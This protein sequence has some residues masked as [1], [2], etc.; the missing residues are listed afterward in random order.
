[1]AVARGK[2]AAKKALWYEGE[3]ASAVVRRRAGLGRGLQATPFYNR[4]NEVLDEAR[5]NR[6]CEEC[7]AKF[8]HQKL[9]RLSL[10]GMTP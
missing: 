9:G 6:F 7:C 8:Y 3:L 10:A 2:T 5:V 1:M 4:L